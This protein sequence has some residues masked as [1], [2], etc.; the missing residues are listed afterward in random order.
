MKFEKKIIDGIE[1]TTDVPVR[2]KSLNKIYALLGYFYVLYIALLL[3]VNIS[4]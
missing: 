1:Q 4:S 3:L 2:A